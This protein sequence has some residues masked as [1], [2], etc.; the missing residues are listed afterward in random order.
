MAPTCGY[1]DD[2]SVTIP[3]GYVQLEVGQGGEV[4]SG[5]TSD[6]L[7]WQRVASVT[8]RDA[9]VLGSTYDALGYGRTIKPPPCTIPMCSFAGE[10][11]VAVSPLLRQ[12]ASISGRQSP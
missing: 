9:A 8:V 4:L 11:G 6:S 12:R 3:L 1:G 5:A 7:A 10:V 2:L